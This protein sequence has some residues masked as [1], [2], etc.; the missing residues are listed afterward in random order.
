MNAKLSHS[1]K[2]PSFSPSCNNY[3]TP[4]KT[5]SV[6]EITSSE[7]KKLYDDQI[8]ELRLE[9][10]AKYLESAPLPKL[11]DFFCREQT[12]NQ[13]YK[14]R[15]INTST[16]NRDEK[17]V[18]YTDPSMARKHHSYSWRFDVKCDR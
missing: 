9:R 15:E 12:K 8:E 6:E 4:T 14:R 3:D 18:K 1:I 17:P 13:T 11:K 5:A 16:E 7:R 10:Q 2:T